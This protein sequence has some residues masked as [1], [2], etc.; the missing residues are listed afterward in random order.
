MY[1]KEVIIDLSNAD[2]DK[3]NRDDIGEFFDRLCID[4][5]DVQV[6]DRHFWDDVGV[7][8]AERQ[9]DPK[10]RGTTAIQFLLFSNVTIHTLDMVGRVY[11]NIFV[12]REFD[13]PRAVE[14]S[15]EFFCAAIEKVTIVERE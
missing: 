4:I 13:I 3:F 2:V 7:P 9:T 8:P 6:C 10:T 14:F 12:C 11:L 15:S 1:G 5:L